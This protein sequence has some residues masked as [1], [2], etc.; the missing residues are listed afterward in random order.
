MS[1]KP[2]HPGE[3]L[4]EDVINPLNM[5]ITEAA[6]RLKVSRQS[7]SDLL[8]C[9]VAL[10]PE[11]AVRVARAT[12]TTPESWLNMQVKPDIWTAG[13]FFDEIEEFDKIPVVQ[14]C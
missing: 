9:K 5:T 12:K 8:R 10:T 11:M 1:R 14:T 13:Q 6:R 4:R 2:V 7:L 3:V